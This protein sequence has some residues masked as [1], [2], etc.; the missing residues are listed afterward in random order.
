MGSTLDPVIG[1]APCDIIVIK[2]DEVDP[3]R[4]IDRIL[5]PSRGR[6]PHEEMAIDI[7]RAIA[8]KLSAEVTVLH[9]APRGSTDYDAEKTRDSIADRMREIP[10]SV[11]IVES[12]DPVSAIV[13]ESE[14]ND[15]LVI[16]ATDVGMFQRILFGSVPEMIARRCSKTVI[17][18]KKKMKIR[19]WFL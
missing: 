13:G 3:E 10:Y 11:K 15:L 17:M 6:S 8:T 7:I 16:G 9:V 4:K 12:N 18:V 19:S 1:Q 14:S 5:F 2:S